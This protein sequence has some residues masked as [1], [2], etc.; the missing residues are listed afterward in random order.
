M[1]LFSFPAREKAAKVKS[2]I[3]KQKKEPE[4]KIKLKIH[5]LCTLNMRWTRLLKADRRK[6]TGGKRRRETGS[7]TGLRR[8]DNHVYSRPCSLL[9]RCQSV[10][11][12]CGIIEESRRP[13]FNPAR[14]SNWL[15]FAN[16]YIFLPST[17]PSFF[18]LGFLGLY[19]SI[20]YWSGERRREPL[21]CT[22][23]KSSFSAQ[24]NKAISLYELIG[25]ANF[26]S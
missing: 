22:Q 4:L 21:G 25:V 13:I 8:N 17:D 11:N 15:S 1:Q 7:L 2:R 16:L 26:K 5:L 3:Q 24:H 6:K 18:V 12:W 10:I 9:F 23:D 14:T 19:I 20:M